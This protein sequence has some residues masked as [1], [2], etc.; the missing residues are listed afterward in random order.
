MHRVFIRARDE[1]RLDH[2]LH[3]PRSVADLGT[4]GNTLVEGLRVAL[5]DDAG[6][7]QVAEL[8]FQAEVNCWVAYPVRDGSL[9]A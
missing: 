8:R 5:Y 7:E 2:W 3:D 1:P 4:I 9:H 6:Q